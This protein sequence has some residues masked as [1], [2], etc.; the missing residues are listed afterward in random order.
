[1]KTSLSRRAATSVLGAW[2]GLA[3]WGGQ[4]SSAWAAA[5]ARIDVKALEARL[6]CPVLTADSGMKYRI[7]TEL[8]NGWVGRRP[9]L[10]AKCSSA[11]QVARCVVY[12]R[13][14]G[15]A[16]SV[17]SGGHH[18][19][20]FAL[21]D[22][23]MTIDLS[24]MMKIDVDAVHKRAVVGPG[25]RIGHLQAVL[26]PLNLFAIGAM[27]STV[28]MA[29]MTMG[30]GYGWFSGEGGFAV[31]N[32]LAAEI[33]TA[34]GKIRRIDAEHDPDLF[35]AIRGGG[36]NFG[37]VTS[38]E[39]RV[40]PL[41]PLTGG[42]LVYA[43]SDARSAAQGWR[44]MCGPSLARELMP[45]LI[46]T[47]APQ[48]SAVPAAVLMVKS[49]L[50]GAAN[51]EAMAKL[52]SFGRPVL[53]TLRPVTLTEV[54]TF[55]DLDGEPGF[56]YAINTHFLKSLPDEA[57]DIM[58]RAIERAPSPKA[59]VLWGPQHG[60]MRERG[61][62]A[63]AHFHRESL[64]NGFI[65]TRWSDPADDRRNIE[66]VRRLWEDL[67]PFSTGQIM[68]NFT[69]ETGPQWEAISYGGN[70]E[71]LSRIK[72]RHDPGNLFSSTM[73]IRPRT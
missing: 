10:I 37:V 73:N 36:G 51:D 20:G 50:R 59:M 65:L 42:L 49:G 48:N 24:D 31:D 69:T 44:A 26:E 9:A 43:G 39:V 52:R 70:L 25:V 72:Q 34:D 2:A 61:P 46:L 21:R 67:K 27:T 71:R 18:P 62:T 16:L 13:E 12:A 15:I 23:G 53:D 33:V 17:K 38:L 8:W 66:W 32:L 28:G 1:M 11:E 57:I 45:A 30:G 22:G 55:A 40:H 7:A 68:M 41:G 63:T 29:G 47:P 60:A 5:P 4:L 35:W 54:Q 3:A 56:R 19:A 64:Y 58:L 6:G 14:N